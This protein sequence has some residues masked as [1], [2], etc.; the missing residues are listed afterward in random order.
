[1][2]HDGAVTKVDPA[3]HKN[4]SIRINR[5]RKKNQ[6]EDVVF[7]IEKREKKK[8][9]ENKRIAEEETKRK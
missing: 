6:N 1:M 4:L 3:E 9:R 5:T 7:R 8:N 2:D